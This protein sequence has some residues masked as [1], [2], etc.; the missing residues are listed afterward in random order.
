MDP[1][2]KN[3]SFESSDEESIWQNGGPQPGK[4]VK[5]ELIEN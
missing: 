5:P 4:E 2:V 1:N 3:S